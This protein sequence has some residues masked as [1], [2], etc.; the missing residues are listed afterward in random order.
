[1]KTNAKYVK[2]EIP[3]HYVRNFC[4]ATLVPIGGTGH[5][6]SLRLFEQLVLDLDVKVEVLDL[7]KRF[8]SGVVVG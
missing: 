6:I 3:W 4:M 1:M 7:L 5:N 8:P 2:K